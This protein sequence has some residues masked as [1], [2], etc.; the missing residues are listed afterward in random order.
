MPVDAALE[1]DLSQVHGKAVPQPAGS[2]TLSPLLL[3][4]MVIGLYSIPLLITIQPVGEPICD[5]D[6]WWHLRVGQWVAEHHTVPD[7]D[8]FAAGNRPWVAYSWLYEVMLWGLYQTFG[9]AGII[10]YR[11]AFAVVTVAALH[12]VIRRFRPQPFVGFGLAVAGTV[13]LAVLFSERPWLFTIALTAVTVLAVLDLREG[14]V[15]WT[16][17]LL[18]LA[19]IVWAN[20]H[21]QFVY[22][23]FVL[24]LGCVAA[25]IDRLL[26]RRSASAETNLRA[27]ILLTITCA[28]ATLVNPYHVRLY[29]VVYEY[30]MQPGPFRWVSELQ[31]L[32]F[33]GL[34]D[35][36][37]LALGGAAAFALGRRSAGGGNLQG[38]QGRPRLDT[39]EA[40]LLVGAA[41]F[42]FRS[43]RDLWLLTLAS[44]VVLARSATCGAASTSPRLRWGH[45]ATA[46][47]VLSGLAGAT[48]WLRNLREAPLR[49]TVARV[50]PA[51][52][53]EL[54][55]ERGYPG[56]LFNDFNWGGFLIWSLPELPVALDGRTNLH[57]DERTLRIGNVWAGTAGWQDDPD[58]SAAGVVIAN[59]QTPLAS[60]LLHDA[61]FVQVHK[62]DLA[63]VFIRRPAGGSPP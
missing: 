37:V 61:R 33:R 15:S 11:A 17:R 23:L 50:F 60:L 21:I 56:P 49:Q 20:T 39:F 53:A 41:I 19:F 35:W 47:V 57:G 52:A 5:P 16:V 63:R 51:Q 59:V 32:E 55:R 44:L 43:R 38:T 24:G 27:P 9:L 3:L 42:T 22:G 34:S 54:V 26:R 13:A 62:D 8:P 25:L 29:G 6:V 7:H 12:A 18:P 36:V 40:L 28:L 46:T 14:R 10:L 4:A 58:L 1:P 30:A 2:Q 48:F 45:L 31:A